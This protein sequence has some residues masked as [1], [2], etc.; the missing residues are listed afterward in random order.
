MIKA[1]VTGG[2]GFIGCYLCQELLDNG[3]DVTVLDHNKPV[4]LPVKFLKGDI[5]NAELLNQT[6]SNCD[7]VFHLAGRL[8]T[9]YLC[10]FVVE[11]VNVN[12]IGSVNIFEAAKTFGFKV[13][14]TGLI[15]EWD[16]PYMITKKATMR[17]GRMYYKEFGTDIT[18]LEVTH[19][20]GPGQRLE[21]Y[22]KAIPTFIV[23]ALNGD[24]L[25]IYGSGQKYM[26]CIYVE[27]I[28]KSLR[29]AAESPKVSGQVFQVGSGE[30]IK[31]IDLAYK[32]ITLTSSKSSIVF[33]PM[34][35]G[36]PDTNES[37]VDIDLKKC[38]QLF[39]WKPSIKFNDGLLKTIEWYAK[40]R[41]KSNVD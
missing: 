17:F 19:V 12:V 39:G 6:T 30:R 4:N 5:F 18:T 8:G 14:N 21:P 13:V 38:E 31:V 7:V 28:A 22:H 9:D 10:N 29:L 1:L 32:I 27:D 20:Y 24:P 15:P 11:A 3:Y 36:E 37:F 26:D 23:K 40:N 2:G 41:P 35:H 25:E 34:R 16:N 33:R